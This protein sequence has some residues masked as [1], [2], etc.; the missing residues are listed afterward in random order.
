MSR[1]YDP[2]RMSSAPARTSP[3]IGRL[4]R[5][6]RGIVWTVL[7]AVMAAGAAGLVSQAW[8]VPG[9]PARAELTYAGDAELNA[10]LDVATDQ[11]RRI[12][13]DVDM[14]ATQAKAS[15]EEVASTD[16]TRL[17]ESLD[18]GGEAAAAIDTATRAL[19]ESLK[20]LPGDG[21]AAV[22][23]F[24]NGT[25]VRR[26]A[27]LAA[28]DAAASLATQWQQVTGRAVDAA[29]LTT[30]IAQHDATVVS[31]ISK[32]VAKNYAEAIPF[33]DEAL[34]TVAEVDALRKRL[35]A[36]TEQT[37]L[38]EWIDRT[39]AYDVALKALY[40]AL[41]KSK[42]ALTVEVQSAR[43]VERL[44]FD[45]LPPDRRTI[46]VIVSEV[47]RGGLTQAVLAIEET[48]SRIDEA[49]A[50]APSQAPAETLGPTPTQAPGATPTQA[51]GQAPTQAP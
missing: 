2:R 38:D 42:G 4:V 12:A 35:I 28:A 11:L 37:V 51:P 16:P 47:A 39:G 13:A 7:F 48:H 29:H 27:I 22:I 23:D 43:R 30:L 18:R 49:L 46:I 31:G 14:L 33:L 20:G 10:S 32:A 44:A 24:S 26:A 34:L 50:E 36:S 15:L 8:H 9:S 5:V 1:C 45:R 6:I 17:Q 25:L 3:S 41:V 19:R 21:P 40:A